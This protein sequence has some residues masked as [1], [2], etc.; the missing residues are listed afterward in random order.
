M[1]KFSREVE[2]HGLHLSRTPLPP[3]RNLIESFVR[4]YVN[5]RLEFRKHDALLLLVLPFAIRIARFA[6]LIASKEENLA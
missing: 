3:L 4:P 1:V 5:T 2:A 6:G